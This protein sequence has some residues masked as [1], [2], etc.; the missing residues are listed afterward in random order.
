ML[1]CYPE[2][3]R[4]L[5][6]STQ[7]V[8]IVTTN[9]AASAV[10]EHTQWRSVGVGHGSAFDWQLWDPHPPSKLNSCVSVKEGSLCFRSWISRPP[11][12]VRPSRGWSDPAGV[13]ADPQP[14]T[15]S[16][17]AEQLHQST[18]S[19]PHLCS[20]ADG[21]PP[22]VSPDL[23]T[24]TWISRSTWGLSWDWGFSPVVDSCSDGPY[25]FQNLVLEP[26]LPPSPPDFRPDQELRPQSSTNDSCVLSN[27]NLF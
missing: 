22:P 25:L 11:T 19:V 5:W 20:S 14:L 10:C 13:P 3:I 12:P 9:T 17:T 26:T 4:L 21:P 1:L 15:A 18:Y 6:L 16:P 2:V 23:P 24:S 27:H 8:V 7:L